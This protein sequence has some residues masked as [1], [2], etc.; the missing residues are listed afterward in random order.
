MK[1]NYLITGG[2]G[3]IG[4]NYVHRL[5]KRGE[6][7]TIFDNLA[8]AGAPRNL[9]WLKKEF[10]ANA[11]EMVVGDV[12]D[13]DRIAEA[14]KGA[15]V[16]VHLAGQVA[17]TTSVTNPRDDFEVNALGTFNVLEAARLSGKKP[18]F[19][20]ASTN[21][22]YGGMDDVEVVEDATRWHYKDL[23]YGAPETQPLDFHSPYGCSKGTGDQYVR[24]YF[25]IYDLPTVVLRQSCIYGPRQFGIE[26]QGWLAWMIIAAVT[27]RKITVYGDG[28]QVRDVLHVDD[29]L[30]AYDA[31]IAN[32]EVAKGQVYN[33]GGGVNNVLAIWAEF[34]PMIESLLG[35]K[36]EVARGD[37]RPGD[38]RVFYADYR[39]A[40]RE[41]GWK[42]K[43][44]LEEGI[45][46]LFQWVK[47]NKDQF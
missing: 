8:R 4:S 35:K 40:E 18:I 42:P 13:A 2:A 3:F 43:I 44:S 31:A 10:G 12:R 24:D 30:D 23:T 6:A 7:V 16:I 28:K 32:I 17:V 14:A 1:K 41:L 22:V 47:E 39:K 27:G 5:L 9:D 21:K 15:D 37:W 33:M 11:F 29:L 26:D 20:Y 38:Q 25:R 36:I 45:E 46:R 34:G 19:L